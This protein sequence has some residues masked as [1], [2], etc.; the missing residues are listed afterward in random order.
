MFF[1]CSPV[2]A[3]LT[4]YH[5]QF[6]NLALLPGLAAWLLI[7]RGPVPPARSVVSALLL[8]L[9]LTVKHVLFLFPAWVLFWP[10]LGTV[11]KRLIYVAFAYSVFGL[12][13][14]P[15]W[16]DPASRAGILRNVFSYRSYSRLSLLQL[17][18]AEHSFSE[19]PSAFSS[20]LTPLWIVTLVAIGLALRRRDEELFPMY[21]LAM[22]ALS[23]A[24]MDQ[25]LA[26]PMLACA[27]FWRNWAAWAFAG[28]ATAALLGS[29]CNVLRSYEVV[30]YFT[31]MPTTQICAATLFLTRWRKGGEDATAARAIPLA[32]A[33]AATL[34]FA[35]AA[36]VWLRTLASP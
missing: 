7:R 27:I 11:R 12:S 30:A 28:A 9:S 17:I 33:R 8:G 21:L 35:G 10:R 14:L 36:I 5:S 32:V 23:P 29:P 31:L 13:F 16:A 1:L 4:G 26:V 19:G 3:L 22:F 6:E 20:I 25:Y 34:V 18:T 2:V 24:L 15:W